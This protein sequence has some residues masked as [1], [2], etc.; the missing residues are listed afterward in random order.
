MIRINLLPVE[1]ATR[2]AERR[3]DLAFGSLVIGAAVL[4]LLGAHAWQGLRIRSVSRELERTAKAIADI[5]GPYADALHLDQQ[6]QELRDKLRVIGQLEARKVGPVRIL[7]DL[8]GA[9]PDKLWLTEFADQGGALRLA[10]VG[11]DEQTVADFLRRLG[12]VPFFRSVDLDE[13]SQ[14][15]QDGVKLKR[16]VIRGQIDY[17]MQGGVAQASAKPAN[18]KP[19]AGVKR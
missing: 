7:A 17:G 12:S 19:T 3:Q 11:V 15:E 1:E 2:A 8:S 13:T 5:D 14:V 9:T 16:F 18:D 10:G 4:V 6:K